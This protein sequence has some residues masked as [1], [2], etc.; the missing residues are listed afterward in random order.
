M[1]LIFLN[2]QS[3]K[4]D[5]NTRNKP[6]AIGKQYQFHDSPS[7]RELDLCKLILFLSAQLDQ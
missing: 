2:H 1:L 5:D 7:R 3:N 6:F 4:R